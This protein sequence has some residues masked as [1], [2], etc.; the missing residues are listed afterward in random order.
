MMESRVLALAG[1]AQALKQV[2]RIAET[3]QADA[4][5]L[6][7]ALDSVFRID[8]T[9]PAEVYGG[10]RALVEVEGLE[11]LTR[12]SQRIGRVERREIQISS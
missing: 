4:A 9:S 5:V 12:Y 3:G 11:A 8:A 6:S 7:T 10:R 2:R 1:M